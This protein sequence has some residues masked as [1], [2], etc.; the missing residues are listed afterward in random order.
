M[1]KSNIN[2]EMADMIGKTFFKIAT[3]VNK[4]F[5]NAKER[6]EALK[7]VSSEIIQ[8]VLEDTFIQM[9]GV[10]DTNVKDVK[11]EEPIQAS[12]QTVGGTGKMF[13]SS[14]STFASTS[15]PGNIFNINDD[16]I[17]IALRK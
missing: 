15:K 10:I 6:E 1:G 7:Q 9:E 16:A 12:N 14:D 4:D 8:Q 13:A 17:K 3:W 5:D 11:K 2:I